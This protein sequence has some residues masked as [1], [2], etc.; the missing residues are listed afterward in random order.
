MKE[1]NLKI[2]IE[3]KLIQKPFIKKRFESLKLIF[4]E[5]VIFIL[6]YMQELKFQT[7]KNTGWDRVAI[8]WSALQHNKVVIEAFTFEMVQYIHIDQRYLV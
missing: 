3:K 7:A 4:I 2:S 8:G 6:C 5:Q 1:H